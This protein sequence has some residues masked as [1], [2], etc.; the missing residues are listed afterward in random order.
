MSVRIVCLLVGALAVSNTAVSQISPGVL[1][2]AHEQLDGIDHCTACHTVGKELL[3][4]KCLDCHKEIDSRI[5]NREGYHAT[6]GA[7]HCAECHSEHH[8]RNFAIVHF[9]TASFDHNSTGFRLEG[10]HKVIA[11]RACHALD[12][13]VS[14]DIRAFPQA[15]KSK[16]YLGLSPACKSCHEDEHKGQFT[17]DCSSCHTALAWKPASRFSHD[18]SR[19]PLT[20]RHKSIACNSCHNKTLADGKT[21]QYV[22]MVFSLCNDCH[23]DPH[24]GKFRQA[25]ST[26]H[27][28]E[29]FR[30][31]VKSQ[32]DHNATR[33]PL[34]GKHVSLKCSQCH[35]DNPKARNASGEFGF[36][37]TKF[38]LCSNCHADAHGGQF[39]SRPDA[40]TCEVCHTVEGFEI[41]RFS[42]KDHESTRFPLTGGH[43]AVV[44][45]NCHPA[46]KVKAQSTMQFVWSGPIQ[47]VMCHQNI[48]GAQFAGKMKNGCATCHTTVTWQSLTFSHENTRFPLRGRHAEIAC[49]RCHIIPGDT[50]KPVQYVGITM[51]C[52]DCHKDEHEGQFSEV[53]QTDCSRCHTAV[54]WHDLHFNHSTQSRFALTGAHE[55]VPCDKCHLK[56]VINNRTVTRYKPLGIQ[57]SDCHSS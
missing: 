36:H 12:K 30:R 13:V 48:H 11:C 24:K 5:K 51:G 35:Q 14:P 17:S 55:R 19:Y 2:T 31:V 34:L 3:D 56:V 53:G 33:F 38:Q 39:H 10:K 45:I 57:C 54:T 4:T 32:F 42:V 27:T 41:V 23:T 20:G 25:C 15:R 18:Q 8:G 52:S 7:R 21:I 9:D 49:N 16:T 22:N 6:I 26:C 29:D 43:A 40:G 44:C 46:G 50:S 47:C 28:T 37:I 1:T